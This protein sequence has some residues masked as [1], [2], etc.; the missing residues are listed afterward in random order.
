VA[1]YSL[2]RSMYR[3]MYYYC[4]VFEKNECNFHWNTIEPLYKGHPWGWQ[5]LS[6]IERCPDYRGQIE[7][8]WPIYDWSLVSLIERCPL[9]EVSLHSFLQ[10]DS[11]FQS[12][13]FGNYSTFW[14]KKLTEALFFTQHTFFDASML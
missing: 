4:K 7:W 8:K 3:Y 13:G 14:S 6:L 12:L 5:M 2:P 1:E 11:Y 10:T 9:R